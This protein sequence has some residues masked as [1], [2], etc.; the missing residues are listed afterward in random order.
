[1]QN[2]YKKHLLITGVFIFLLL[3]NLCAQSI[4]EGSGNNNSEKK[5]TNITSE[6]VIPLTNQT[7][8]VQSNAGGPVQSGSYRVTETVGQPSP[9]G[10]LSSTSYLS[11]SGFIPTISAGDVEAPAAPTALT[12][13][14]SNPSPW[15][16][17]PVFTLSWTNPPDPSGINRAYYKLGGS[18]PNS[19]SDTTGSISGQ[20]PGDVTATLEGGQDLYLWLSDGKGNV[21]FINY[22]HVVLNFD[23]SPPITTADSPDTSITEVF[24]VIWS[25]A[26]DPGGSGLTGF[27]NVQVKDVSGGS[28]VDWKVNFNGISDMYTGAHGHTYYFEAAGIDSA[29]NSEIFT[30][31][32]E[33]TTVVDT[34]A[35]DTQAPA[36][37]INLT[38]GG[39][40]PSPWQNSTTF[41]LDWTNPPDMSGIDRAYYNLNSAPDSNSDTTGSISGQS[42]D[43]V[44][45]TVEG[46]QDLF[47]WLVDGHGNV[48]YNNYS[49]VELRYDITKP[50]GTLADSPDTSSTE[51]F[52]VT[53]SGA[54]D[55]G[56]SGLTGAYDVRVK[57]GTGDW[58][59]W[60]VDFT[61][62]NSYYTGVHGQT[63]YFEAAAR[64][65]AGNIEDTTGT[66]E[67][68]TVVDTSVIDITAPAAP[69]SLIAGGSSP[70]P[71]QNNNI[72]E[73]DWTNPHDISGIARAYYNL[74]SAPETNTDTSGS[75]SGQP[76]VNVAATS[77]GGQSLYVWLVDGSGNTDYQNNSSVTLNLDQTNPTNSVASS[78]TTSNSLSFTVSWT[79]GN[80]AGGSGLS[81]YYDVKVKDGTEDWT[82]WKENFNGT[83]DLY[84]GVNG[85][86][87]SFEAAARDI[88]GNIE[89][90]TENPEC[91]TEVDTSGDITAP[92]APMNLTASPS[93]WTNVNDFSVNWTNPEPDDNIAGAWHKIGAAPLNDDDGS[94]DTNDIVDITG[95]TADNS[96]EFPVYVW[97]QDQSGNHSYLNAA[98]TVIR[99]DSIAPGINPNLASNYNVGTAITVVP[100]FSD[101]HSGISNG[102]LYYQRAGEANT[103]QSVPFVDDS[104]AIPVS[105]VTQQG[106]EFAIDATDSANN[107]SR[108]PENGFNTIQLLLTGNGGMQLDN[109]GQPVAR[110]S[111]SSVNSYRIFSVPFVLNNKTPAVVLED[112]LGQYDNTKWRFFEVQNTSLREYDQIKNSSIVNPGKGFLL[113]VNMSG[114]YIGSGPGRTPN[115][116]DYTQIP[117]NDGWNLIGNPYDFD[118][119]FNNLSVNGNPPD[120]QYHGSG[121]W[122]SAGDL[123]KW[124]GL[125]IHSTG[126]ATLTIVPQAGPS[127]NYKISERFKDEDWGIKLSAKGESST[128][129][130]NYIGVFTE[131]N[132]KDRN[133]WHEP[134]RLPEAISL[135]IKPEKNELF[136]NSN[137]DKSLLSTLIQPMDEEGNYWDFEIFGDNDGENVRLELEYFADFPEE[138][139]KY[140]LDFNFNIVHELDEEVKY[141]DFKTNYRKKCEFRILVG[142]ESY[143][144]A[145]SLGLALVPTRFE[146]R[147]NFPNPFN[148][149][150]HMIFSLPKDD[151][152]TLEVF[153]LLGQKIKSLIDNDNFQVGYH[154]IEWDGKNGSG[155]NVASGMYVF[156][157]VSGNQTSIK[158]GILIR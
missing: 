98:S 5:K 151:K 91:T 78:I 94:F 63:Y 129:L 57:E 20:P 77:Q 6:L 46:G 127:S 122:I 13:G 22:A 54:S 59:D 143:V 36:E 29:G 136:K 8:S 60:L 109:S 69:I 147:Q 33:D 30:D 81:G 111:G 93:D 19:N 95:I 142:N 121:G 35:S 7:T 43:N 23:Q 3:Q 156:R 79:T 148:P 125:A 9:V 12:A 131:N 153:N 97:L 139:N 126:S 21:N 133:F 100:T 137:L 117:L 114:K 15:Q 67:C 123:K 157:L 152:V 10:F 87:Y 134:P 99:F 68:T 4:N 110:Y 128:D 83:E 39:A 80:D 101:N 65:S 16:N 145:N 103:L 86:S 74:N 52:N 106:V 113:I 28:W 88:A 44:I 120:A 58:S 34:T 73:I 89:V 150:T 11:S 84:T 48:D 42:P 146:L 31:T 82:N 130:D 76:P 115:I 72:F 135:R 61:G 119:P 24:T 17:T 112:D 18:A 32:A 132:D 90:F 38:A 51:I 105:Y 26:T 40:N 138:F 64:D 75:L 107:T 2:K 102:N 47:L 37:P 85:H 92:L 66:A 56:G 70:S 141:I 154:T 140:L 62:T 96:G 55:L 149:N 124:E 71:W 14:G 158:K 118:I 53:W 27:Y 50:T 144:K 25:G 45:A 116:S 41:Q 155:E 104:A 1:M 108:F 49:V